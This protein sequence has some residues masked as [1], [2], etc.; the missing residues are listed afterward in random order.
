M[1]SGMDDA[2][3][4]GRFLR[5]RREQLTPADVGLPHTSRRRTPG[6]RREEVAAL[7]G[8]SIDYLVRLEQGRDRHP[9]AQ[10]VSALASALVL[11][12]DERLHLAKLA[13]CASAPGM[14]PTGSGAVDEVPATVRALVAR[15]HPT[16]AVVVGPWHQVLAHNPAFAAV[17]GA[18]GLL[19]GPSPNLVRFTFLDPRARTAYPAWSALADD[20][21]AVLRDAQVRWRHDERMHDLVEELLLVPDFAA[22]WHA[23]DVARKRRGTKALLHP[24]AGSLRIDD[25]VLLLADDTDQRLITW[26]P[27]DDA[28]AHA[29]DVLTATDVPVSP[30]QLRVVG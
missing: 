20:Q 10:V 3:E 16:P 22:R 21:V 24:V 2:N 30:A 23:H 4:L 29:F 25:E 9:S 15:L 5:S 12:A 13:A 14:C 19:D 8:L 7:A 1:L 28:T 11:D 18:V 26:L 6:L 27:A 17:V